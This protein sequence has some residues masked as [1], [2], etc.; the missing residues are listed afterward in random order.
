MEEYKS[1]KG[2]ED[3]KV[4]NLGNVK[5]LKYGKERV[6]NPGVSSPGY[7]TVSLYKEIVKKKTF[8]IHQLVAMAFLNHELCGYKLVINHIDFNPL[9]NNVNNLEV[10]TQRKNTNKK[11]LN[12]SSK[13]VGVY[14]HKYNNK[15][16]ASITVDGKRKHLGYFINEIKAAEAYQIALNSVKKIAQ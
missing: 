12:S 6:L 5:S 16:V 4:S 10:I 9:N 11:H 1:I 14:W 3:Y 7:L 8:Q 13:Y 2:Y 15:W